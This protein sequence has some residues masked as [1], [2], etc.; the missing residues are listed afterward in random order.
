MLKY[1][2]L[3]THIHI[4]QNIYIV[5]DSTNVIP[6]NALNITLFLGAAYASVHREGGISCFTIVPVQ[7]VFSQT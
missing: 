2:H 7:G 5:A 3:H 6:L 4:Q 1:T